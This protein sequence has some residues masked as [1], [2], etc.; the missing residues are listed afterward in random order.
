GLPTDRGWDLDTLLHPDATRQGAT[1]VR[2]GGFLDDVAQF[3]A[4]FFGISPREAASMD[5]QQRLLLELTWEALERAGIDPKSMRGSRTGVFAGTSDQDYADLLRGSAELA[6][7]Y[8]LTGTS[9]AVLAGRV[10]YQFGLEGPA[11]TVDTACSSSLVAMHLAA[12]ALRSGE[13]GLALAGGATVMATP[14][15]LQEF[16]KQGLS[17]DGRCKA[18]GAGAD[19]TGFAEGAGLLVL[20]RL[21][22]A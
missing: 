1:H 12:Q 6:D 21:S 9:A 17:A 4:R 3:D 15:D 8:L 16:D 19:G 20:E 10:S 18:F 22:D 5:P 11:L 13:C 2:G 14:V 7:G